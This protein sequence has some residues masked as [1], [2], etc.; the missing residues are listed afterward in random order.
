[1]VVHAFEA[2]LAALP[3]LAEKT[4]LPETTVQPEKMP[5]TTVQPEK[6][7]H[8]PGT[9]VQPGTMVQP[10]KMVLPGKNQEAAL[11]KTADHQTICFSTCQKKDSANLND[12]HVALSGTNQV[13]LYSQGTFSVFSSLVHA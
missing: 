7:V 6:T 13:Y 5:G 2:F 3:G 1:M 8:L 10:E 4:V 11:V 12:S 9:T